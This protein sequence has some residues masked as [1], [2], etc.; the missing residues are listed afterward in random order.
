MEL[1]TAMDTAAVERLRNSV[2]SAQNGDL[3]AYRPASATLINAMA[4]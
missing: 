2:G 3:K 4:A 1:M